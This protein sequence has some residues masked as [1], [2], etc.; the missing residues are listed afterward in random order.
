MTACLPS[1]G[2]AIALVVAVLLLAAYADHLD[3]SNG[4]CIRCMK[5]RPRKDFARKLGWTF[6]TEPER[7]YCP[8]CGGGES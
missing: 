7:W 4:R 2:L 8:E 6:R 1:L 3:A 5:Q